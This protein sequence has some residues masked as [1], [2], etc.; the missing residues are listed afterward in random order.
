MVGARAAGPAGKCQWTHALQVHPA[1]ADLPARCDAGDRY[2]ACSPEGELV[3]VHPRGVSAAALIHQGVQLL[4]TRGSLSPYVS[5]TG[6]AEP[7][8][9]IGSRS[10]RLGRRARIC[11]RTGTLGAIATRTK[12]AKGGRA[13]SVR[14][15]QMGRLAPA[16]H[17][18]VARP[19]ELTVIRTWAVE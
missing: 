1:R 17:A 6:A 5:L 7:R 11:S 15:P 16:H 4:Y 3:A 8:P 19:C 13:G 10:S 14:R 2:C 12:G 18:S 9:V